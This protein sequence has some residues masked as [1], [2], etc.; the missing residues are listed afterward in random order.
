LWRILR[1]KV[2]SGDVKEMRIVNRLGARI[3][4]TRR[5]DKIISA[6]GHRHIAVPI[7]MGRSQLPVAR[8]RDP[9]QVFPLTL[10]FPTISH[11]SF[12][13]QM[14]LM[15]VDSREP[16]RLPQE[17]I[18]L[19]LDLNAS[20]KRSLKACSRVARFLVSK[21]C[22]SS[23]N[24]CIARYRSFRHTSQKH[25]FSD[26]RL[27]PASRYW[28]KSRYLTLQGFSQILSNSPHL[29]LNVRS[30]TVIEGT[31]VGSVPWMRTDA[32]P[33]ILSMLANLNNLSIES[34]LWLD[35]NSFPTTL[36]TAL[37][38][39]VALPSLTSIRLHHLRFDRSTEL[40]SLLQSC[41]HIDSLVFSQVS[42]QITDSNDSDA[43][44]SD[45]RLSLSSLTLDPS[46]LPLLH[47]VTS[48]VDAQSLRYL[49]TTVSTPEMEAEIQHLLDATEN[50][51]HYHVHLSHHHSMCSVFTIRCS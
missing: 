45:T 13:R 6:D 7:T 46:L 50:L 42:V 27:M 23:S 35:W 10:V 48:T 34:D 49:H 25:I 21:R 30:L 36:I 20:D 8:P 14:V 43:A 5:R 33:A 19:I 37:H 47:S 28:I 24:S 22:W 9:V 38:L 32:F 1:A 3:R 12:T 17:L 26:I 16:P 44:V 18:D 31:G 11:P 51:G 15:A 39:T 40:V 29:A 4:Q 2:L 41:R